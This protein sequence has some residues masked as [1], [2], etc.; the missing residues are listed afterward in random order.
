MRLSRLIAKTREK[1]SA[2][3]DS[4]PSAGKPVEKRRSER[5]PQNFNTDL[6]DANRRSAG[7]AVRLVDMSAVGVGIETSLVL[8][9]GDR[10]GLQLALGD[11]GPP[12]AA[13]ARVRWGRPEGYYNVYGLEFEGL[14]R[15]ERRRLHYRLNPNAL[16]LQDIFDLAVQALA[17]VLS[18]YVAQD[19]ISSDPERLQTFLLAMP[20]VCVAA[21]GGIVAW[22]LSSRY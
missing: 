10:L 4:S 3:L 15:S 12:I 1:I 18:V 21:A 22:L 8:G 9:I 20:L 7:E 19:W 14:G 16:T 6:L 5:L 11:D 2:S 17:T 13:T